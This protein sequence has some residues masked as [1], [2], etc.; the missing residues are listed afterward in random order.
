MGDSPDIVAARQVG[1]TFVFTHSRFI[2]L[3]NNYTAGNERKF[4]MWQ[5]ADYI[6]TEH[7]EIIFTQQD[8]V[9][10][11][12]KVIYSLETYDITTIRASIG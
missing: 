4:L 7:H 9:D 5:V 3:T 1:Y 8:V 6:G 2:S 12:D 11:L 10:V